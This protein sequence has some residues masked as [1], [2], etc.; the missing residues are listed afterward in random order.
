MSLKIISRL[1]WVLPE[2]SNNI[3]SKWYLMKHQ[4]CHF[5]NEMASLKEVGSTPDL[6]GEGLNAESRKL[7]ALKY[8]QQQAVS[9]KPIF[10]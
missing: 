6:S 3:E 5:I 7:I 4:I 9:K 8:K 10:R 1:F 2:V